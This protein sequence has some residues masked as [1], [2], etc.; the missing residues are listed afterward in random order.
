MKE[1]PILFSAPM[2]RAILKGRKTQTRRLDG[3][4]DINLNP[5]GWKWN[6]ER[7][8]S[9]DGLVTMWLGECP[10]GVPG[11]R[12]WVRETW[13]IGGARLVDPCVN[14]RADG[15]QLPLIG[16]ASPD[17][18]SIVGNRHGVNDADLLKVKEG[19]R[20]S[21]FMFHWASR[22]TLEIT[23]VRVQRLQEISE[24]EAQAEGIESDTS[25]FLHAGW[26]IYGDEQN[27][28]T[29]A[30]KSFCSL[31]DSINA[32]HGF[33]WNQNPWVWTLTFKVLND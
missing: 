9:K 32:A 26:R 29:S 27:M 6:G 25:A 5:D 19:W 30:T 31:W 20:S 15:A 12:L 22:I 23:D 18:W 21:R 13:G 16:H 10:K 17:T 3:L 24:A 11:D 8:D 4:H 28:T 33:G 7:F 14:Y 1:R 2:V